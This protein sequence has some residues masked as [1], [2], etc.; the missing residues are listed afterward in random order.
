MIYKIDGARLVCHQGVKPRN[1]QKLGFGRVIPSSPGVSAY[2]EIVSGD[3][4]LFKVDVTDAELNEASTFDFFV[5]G[6]HERIRYYL[7]DSK[8]YW[9]DSQLSTIEVRRQLLNDNPGRGFKRGH[10][11]AGPIRILQD[12]RTR[13]FRRKGIRDSVKKEVFKRDGGACVECGM[14]ADLQFDHVIPVAMG[15]SNEAENIQILCG[16]CNRA[17]GAKLTIE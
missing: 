15:G 13:N 4:V 17:K 14:N 8:I 10:P 2:L 11:P 12:E 9:E 16:P 6:A 7:F 5:I 1:R 3:Q